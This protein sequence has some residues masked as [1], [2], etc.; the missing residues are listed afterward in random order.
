MNKNTFKLGICKV[1]C[2]DMPDLKHTAETNLINLSLLQLKELS[3]VFGKFPES[4]FQ[5]YS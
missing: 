4:N 1:Y 3:Y 5:F 2:N